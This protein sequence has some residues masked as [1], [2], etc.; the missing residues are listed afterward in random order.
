MEKGKTL[1]LLQ[2]PKAERFIAVAAAS[3][4]ARD[5]F[6]SR[7]NQL[8]KEVG[9]TLPKGASPAVIDAARQIVQKHG[10]ESLRKVAKLHF[11]TT[12]SVLAKQ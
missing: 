7:L 2:T 1:N 8:S 12:A 11:K 3:V 4:L 9:L 5:H 10:A 6:L